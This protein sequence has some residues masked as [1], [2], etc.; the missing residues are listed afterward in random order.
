MS[1]TKS[2]HMLQE[3]FSWHL[4]C[5]RYLKDIPETFPVD[6]G[7]RFSKE[8]S[9]FP[10]AYKPH[11]HGL[12]RDITGYQYNG[13]YH[14]IDKG[15]PQWPQTF[16]PVTNKI[17]VKN[18]D[19]LKKP[20]VFTTIMVAWQ[21]ETMEYY[22]EYAANDMR[23]KGMYG[24][25]TSSEEGLSRNRNKGF[26]AISQQLE[27]FPRK[28]AAGRINQSQ[29]LDQN[30]G[31]QPL[32]ENTN[33]A[34]INRQ[35]SEL[36]KLPNSV[37]AIEVGQSEA[38][39]KPH[40]SVSGMSKQLQCAHTFMFAVCIICSFG[41]TYIQ[42]IMARRVYYIW[43]G[44][45]IDTSGSRKWTAQYF[46]PHGITADHQGTIWLTDVA[47][48]QVF[49]IPPGQTVPKMT[50]GQKFQHGED[51]N[52]FCKPSDVSVLLSGEFFV[53]DGYCYS[54]VLKFSKDGT[55]L[56]SFGKRNVQFGA[57]PPV[58]TFDIPH[59][60][61]V[62][63]EHHLVCVADRENNRIQC[64]DLD[65][66]F[67]QVIK[68]PEFG[69]RLFA[70]EY[71][72]AHGGLLYAV[73]GPAFE[74]CWKCGMYQMSAMPRNRPSFRLILMHIEIASAELLRFSLEDF[75][76][77]QEIWRK[78]IRE[79]FQKM[80]AEGSNL[81][82]LEEE[83]IKRRKEELRHAQ[84]VREHYES[85][86]EHANNLYMELTACMLQLE[87][88]ER[89]LIKREQQLTL[90]NKHRK[91]IVR[92]IIK[93]QE[94]LDRLG[95]KCTRRS[96]SEV[97]T[98]DSMKNTEGSMTTSSELVPPSPTKLRT[99]KSRHR[100]NNSRESMKDITS[101]QISIYIRSITGHPNI[102]QT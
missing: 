29:R 49:K 93:A 74:I 69:P 67:K 68:C 83:L 47:M 79:N 7:C 101:A 96:G 71:C 57:V 55:F 44:V 37:R 100:R 91:S 35:N 52:L 54:R 42:F 14:E 6:V 62:S 45:A 61:T 58:V 10:F 70:L 27:H 34:S 4:H 40:S 99:R 77:S 95:K 76:E 36:R 39:H 92:P 73:N 102:R 63:E 3:F 50:L 94:K 20:R 28:N 53:S 17:E 31:K 11:A 89:E 24:T 43:S 86:L 46:M 2:S 59:S 56:M 32:S 64:F 33:H 13:S 38:V 78:E 87:K 48:H 1:H 19:Y 26:E 51:T 84:D 60:I 15:H 18:G 30:Q 98:P 65:G 16:Y 81:P 90:Y 82:Q 23:E 12:G 21:A 97:T 66:N 8:K 22:D 25:A 41:E 75:S 88:R 80:K 72:P 85:K 5:L 9:I